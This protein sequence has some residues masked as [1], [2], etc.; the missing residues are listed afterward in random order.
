MK[1]IFVLT[2]SLFLF[3]I[4]SP[5]FAQVQIINV[6]FAQITGTDSDNAKTLSSLVK[7]RDISEQYATGGLYL[8]THYGNLEELFQKENQ[9]LIDQMGAKFREMFDV[10]MERYGA[11]PMRFKGG[12]PPLDLTGGYNDALTRIKNAFDPNNILSPNFGL[13]KEVKP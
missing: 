11:I 2:S 3:F 7:V 13:F 5:T 4:T 6:N 8:I 1:K 12:Y 9:K 10:A